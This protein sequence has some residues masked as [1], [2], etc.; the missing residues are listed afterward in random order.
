LKTYA[1]ALAQYHLRPEAKFENGDYLDSGP[2]CR[3]HVQATQINY[4]GKE[5]NRWE[6]QFF[7][8]MDEGAAIEYG[9]DPNAAALFDEL[10]IA[11]GKFGKQSVA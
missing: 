2:T 6:E 1:Q 4:I 3:R 9:A 8:G 5:A 10:M 7:L 11:I